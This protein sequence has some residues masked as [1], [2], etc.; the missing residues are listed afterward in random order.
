[1]NINYG[2][3]KNAIIVMREMLKDYK[4]NNDIFYY[5]LFFLRRVKLDEYVQSFDVKTIAFVSKVEANVLNRYI[6][7]L[8]ERFIA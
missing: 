3:V 1:M 4:E 2:V 5:N 8:E 7:K 6:D